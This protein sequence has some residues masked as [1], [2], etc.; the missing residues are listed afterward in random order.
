LGSVVLVTSGVSNPPTVDPTW[1][2]GR[3]EQA[4]ESRSEHDF[5]VNVHTDARTRLMVKCV[6]SRPPPCQVAQRGRRLQQHHAAVE[7]REEN[8]G[9]EGEKLSHVAQPVLRHCPDRRQHLHELLRV[10]VVRVVFV[11]VVP[12]RAEGSLRDWDG[13]SGFGRIR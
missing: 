11:V 13:G 5:R 7:N 12:F 4:L 6:F 3:S 2:Q 8:K 1:Q 10:Q 9:E